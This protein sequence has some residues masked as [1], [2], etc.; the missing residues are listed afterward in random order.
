MR[1]RCIIQ[2]CR[3]RHCMLVHGSSLSLLSSTSPPLSSTSPSLFLYL[4]LPSPLL[5]L[6]LPLPSPLPPPPFSSTSP[7]LLLYLPLPSPLP[8]PTFSPLSSTSPQTTSVPPP[9]RPCLLH[10]YHTACSL[11]AHSTCLAE[12][13]C[14]SPQLI[15]TVAPC[16]ACGRE[17]LWGELV[18][19][20]KPSWT[21]L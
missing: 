4:P 12:R 17:L 6:Y 5:L 3:Y 10:C 7:S 21:A 15:P 19:R 20:C 14:P 8:P 18:R 1:L 11:S 9:P 13:V 16:P 2:S